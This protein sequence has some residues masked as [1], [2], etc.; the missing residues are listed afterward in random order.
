V[1]VFRIKEFVGPTQVAWFAERARKAGFGDVVEG[2]QTVYCD[3]PAED[4][5]AAQIAYMDGIHE[6]AGYRVAGLSP[7]VIRETEQ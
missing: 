7:V 2:T 3:V 5:T 1:K 6:A 4:R